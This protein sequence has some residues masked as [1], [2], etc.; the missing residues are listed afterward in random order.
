MT[1]CNISNFR[2]V[3]TDLLPGVNISHETEF[4]ASKASSRK[5]FLR[6]QTQNLTF[7]LICDL[8]KK[9]SPD[10]LVR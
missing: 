1:I 10:L 8:R 9:D 7:V 2:C 6:I 3:A 4:L 5:Q